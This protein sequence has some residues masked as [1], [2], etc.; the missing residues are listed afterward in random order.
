MITCVLCVVVA[1]QINGMWWPR[2]P[3]VV[4]GVFNFDPNSSWVASAAVVEFTV[5]WDRVGTCQQN[6]SNIEKRKSIN[7]LFIVVVHEI[8]IESRTANAR[9]PTLNHPLIHPS[10]HLSCIWFLKFTPSGPESSWMMLPSRDERENAFIFH[11]WRTVGFEC[12]HFQS[13]VMMTH[14]SGP[15][16][17]GR[18]DANESRVLRG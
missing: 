17:C 1:V 15:Q 5:A 11:L 14:F 7:L 18:S 6:R 2:V 16:R 8:E 9:W 13:M 3:S 12:A 10:I 4:T